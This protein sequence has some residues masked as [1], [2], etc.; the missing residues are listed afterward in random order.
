MQEVLKQYLGHGVEVFVDD[1]IIHAEHKQ[2]Y[3]DLQLLL[4][5]RYP[6]TLHAPVL[7]SFI[8]FLFFFFTTK[9]K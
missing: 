3:I 6:Q 1:I 7:N 5:Q 9:T 2:R 4:Q 8:P